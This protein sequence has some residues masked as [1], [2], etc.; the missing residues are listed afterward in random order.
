[1]NIH[2]LLRT[3]GAIA[4]TLLCGIGRAAAQDDIATFRTWAMTPPMGWNSWDCYFSSVTEKEVMQNAQYLV[5]NDLVR[6]GWEYVVIDIRWYCNHPSLGGG[7]YNQQGTQDYVLDEYG[8][9]LPSPTRFPSCMVDGK[10]QGFK[11][12]ADKLHAMG[13][14]FGI[15][16]MRGV[17]K[18]VVGS[19]Y[20]LKGSEQTPWTQVYNGTT[21]P[22]AWLGDN[23]RVRDNEYGQ[24][25]YNSI[26]DLYA[27]W[28]VDFLKI[29]DLSRPFYTDEVQMIRRA[30]DQTGRPIVLSLSPGKTQ[31]SCAEA[32]LQNANMW[33]MMDD[34]WD[35]WSAVDA[36]F[37][38]AHF[39]SQ[40]ARPGNY[41]D[42]DMLPLG[43]IAATVA[44]PGYTNAD[45]GH[46]TQL[47]QNEQL[48]MMTLWGIC[49]SPLF[50]G[51][52]MTKNDDFTLSLMTNEEYHQM[53]KYGQ[54][55]HQVLADE[56][57]GHTVWTSVDPATGNRYLALFQRNNTRWIV[58]Q[59]ALYRSETV[60]YTTDGHAVEVD[61]PW[62]EGSK[63]LVLVVDDGG[64][65]FN[66]DHGDWINPTLV[67]RDGTEV[68]LTGT[69][70]TRDFT[71]SYFNR[72]RENAN[73]DNGGKMKVMGRSYDR[74][75]STDANA[76]IFFQ[77][78]DELDV[79][80]FRALAAADDSGI[81]QSGATTSIRFFVFDQNPL[82]GEQDNAVARSGL[83]SRTGTKS[84]L[85]EANIEGA[86][87][88]QIVVSNWDDGFAY[89]RADLINPVLIDG[90]GN[91]V[92]LTTL[93]P[94]SYTSEWGSLH[95]NHNVENGPLQVDGRTYQK[96]LGMNARCT[97]VY[98]LPAGH[99]FKTFR[100]LCGYDSSCDRDNTSASGTTMEFI[101]SVVKEEP[102]AFDLTLLGYAPDEVVPIY[103]IWEQNDLG[104]VSGS[105]TLSVPSHGVRLLRLGDNKAD[106]IRAVQ[107]RDKH[108]DNASPNANDRTD[109]FDLNGRHVG[110]ATLLSNAAHKGLYIVNGNKV[111]VR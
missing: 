10:N 108:G 5:D 44:D 84:K 12:L 73:V 36:V 77:I 11:A 61:I 15:H 106:A 71:Q 92:S 68:A 86:G 8:R 52:E 25:Y 82:A 35:N 41:A 51:G 21:S 14:K 56:E 79:V 33:R 74:G 20:K 64:D 100:A 90:E 88:L 103:D 3:A 97:L 37:P 72:V 39:W 40:Y 70:K 7:W 9:Y 75:F 32:C 66:Y 102:Y 1:M 50:F 105:I 28:G 22:C 85:L 93:T 29:D 96:G 43:H 98:D 23:L 31:Y 46:W 95:V 76:A 49:H 80:R 87:K 2:P 34:L 110:S 107:M 62:P 13:L 38:E 48:T 54:D 67:L 63:T 78:P 26:M 104:T 47:T 18:V 17:P 69:Y 16:L 83:I 42:C 19:N 65:N 59:K 27:E 99:S 89:D 81:G 94:S 45:P 60:A 24:L 58:G 91:E 55:A 101:I 111:I 57:N 6:H 30:I 109:V 53:H 4:L